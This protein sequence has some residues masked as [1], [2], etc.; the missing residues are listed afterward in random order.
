MTV[1]SHGSAKGCRL[2]IYNCIYNITCLSDQS[3]M[4][5]TAIEILQVEMVESEI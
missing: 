2:K 1:L 4:L 3:S 5:K